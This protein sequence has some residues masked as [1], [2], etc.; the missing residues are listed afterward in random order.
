[1]LIERLKRVCPYSKTEFVPKRSN[2]IFATKECRIAFHNERNG[3]VR[4]KRRPITYQLDRNH[5][6]LDSLLGD[7][8]E[9][10]VN[11]HYLRGAGFSYKIITHVESNNSNVAYGVFDTIFQKINEEE[12]L[13]YRTR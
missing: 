13:I 6:I 2:Q 12:Y 4:R 3:L 11:K 7:K 9:T 5:K 8:K 1:M 10:T